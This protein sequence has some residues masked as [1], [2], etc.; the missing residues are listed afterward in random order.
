MTDWGLRMSNS[1]S[2][3]PR[4]SGLLVIAIGVLSLLLVAAVEVGV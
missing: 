3:D 4:A 1:P 2:S